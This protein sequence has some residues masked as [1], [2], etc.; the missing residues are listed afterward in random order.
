MDLVET[1]RNAD[2]KSQHKTGGVTLVC[3]DDSS[4]DQSEYGRMG[5]QTIVPRSRDEGGIM[6]LALGND[7]KYGKGV[8]RRN[9]VED[10]LGNLKVESEEDNF[11]PDKAY[12]ALDLFSEEMLEEAGVELA[13]EVTEEVYDPLDMLQKQAAQALKNP[14]SPQTNGNG[15]NAMMLQ[16]MGLLTQV[17]SQNAPLKEVAPK[18][19]PALTQSQV[20]SKNVI[21]SG[22]FGQ[23]TVQYSG[24]IIKDEFIVLISQPN[25]PT[26]YK[27]PLSAQKPISLEIDNKE[28]KVVNLGLS[29]NHKGDILLL[30]PIAIITK[31][32][33]AE[34]TE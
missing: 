2:K 26:M 8:K 27:P 11:R 21:F 19:K 28:F 30:M 25:Q 13:E 1:Y 31:D 29:F 33:D 9:I 7:C 24:V 23:F 5:N 22:D 34:E 20:P 12:E 16:M 4:L 3:L 32:S 17:V 14:G 10:E 15:D 18:P 6:G